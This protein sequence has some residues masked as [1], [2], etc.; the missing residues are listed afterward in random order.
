MQLKVHTT[1]NITGD[2]WP[3]CNKYDAEIPSNSLELI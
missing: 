3:V 1:I 2:I